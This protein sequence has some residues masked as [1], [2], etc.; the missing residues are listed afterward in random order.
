MKILF[1]WLLW[2]GLRVGSSS[3]YGSV[4]L[5]ELF[6]RRVLLFK[7]F[8]LN[9]Q[10]ALKMDKEI[11]NFQVGKSFDALRINVSSLGSSLS[12]LNRETVSERI[13]RFI[14]LGDQRNI[15]EVYV[16]GRKVNHST[17]RKWCKFL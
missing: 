5:H 4:F 12:F 13:Q 6:D 10:A 7:L 15:T 17:G 16:E 8:L 1:I 2:E 14:M 9:I 3:T 11:G